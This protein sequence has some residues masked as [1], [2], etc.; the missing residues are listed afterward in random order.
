MVLRNKRVLITG[1]TGFIGS[2][3]TSRIVNEGAEVLILTRY[4]SLERSSRLVEL[5]DKINVVEADIRNVDSLKQ[6][7]EIKPDIIYH[8][9]AYNHVGDS[10]LHVNEAL[11][12]NCIGTANLLDAYDGYERFVYMSTSEIYGYQEEVPFR[13]SS[14]PNPISPYAIGK[15]SGELYCR[16]KIRMQNYPIV[17][18]R[19]FNTFGPYQST[20]AI[21]PE[22]IIKC[23]TGKPI[24]STEGIQTREF[25][26]IDNQIDGLILSVEKDA[27]V[28]EIINVGAAEEIS[29]RD[30]IRKIHTM[31]E[32][33]S[34]LRIG[35]MKYR[36]TEI[37][38]MYCDNQRARDILD[39]IPKVK[40]DEGLSRTITWFKESTGNA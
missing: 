39:W 25:N 18:L 6:I 19:P 17:I 36:P 9:A 1:A 26:Y 14:I 35:A 24:E 16:M 10:F 15:Y 5:W 27:S 28:G 21:I 4:K 32:S 29:I 3:L 22:I 12:T 30:L 20:R 23:L 11:K 13:E 38:R 7:K 2:H 37:W 40:F 33:K 34:E 31:T 8:L